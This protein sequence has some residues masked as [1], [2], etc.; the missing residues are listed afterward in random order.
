MKCR[1][2]GVKLTVHNQS[3]SL[4]KEKKRL[5]SACNVGRVKE[6]RARNPERYHAQLRRTPEQKR[7]R[8]LAYVPKSSRTIACG[9]CGKEVVA[10][11]G[12][13]LYCSKL[14][15][16]RQRKYV[17]RERVCAICGKSMP[18]HKRITAVTC[19]PICNVRKWQREHPERA[20]QL[21]AQNAARRRARKRGL[22]E[23]KIDRHAIYER[24]RGRCHL[25]GRKVAKDEFALDHLIPIALGG[26]TVAANLRV[27]HVSC[28]SR[29]WIK[30]MGEQLMVIG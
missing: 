24:D 3:P 14:C 17:H 13:Q 12:R 1:E 21:S 8:S 23:E 16:E 28:N 6:W 9:Y 20:R 26:G 25:C 22:P 2:C 30:P 19:S 29:K 15:Q 18:K 10:T 27:A 5:C 4:R 7:Q 11:G